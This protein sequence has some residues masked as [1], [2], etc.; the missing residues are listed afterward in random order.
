MVTPTPPPVQPPTTV[1]YQND[2]EAPLVPIAV[3]NWCT[4]LDNTDIN[5]VYGTPLAQFTQQDTVET[6]IIDSL[7]NPT[8]PYVDPSGTG[9]A[10]SLI[11]ASVIDDNLLALNFDPQGRRYINVAMDISSIGINDDNNCI[12]SIAI[13]DPIFRVFAIDSPAGIPLLSG[14]VLDQEDMMGQ[15]GPNPWTFLWTRQVVS[16]DVSAST[17]GGSVSIMFQVLQSAIAS[18]DNLVITASDNP[19][20]T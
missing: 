13:A 4:G 5:T 12:S 10:Y 20:A 18:L 11:M 7:F 8:T 2:F 3:G 16:L 6:M 14:T 17:A 15:M 1:L 9:G 19:L